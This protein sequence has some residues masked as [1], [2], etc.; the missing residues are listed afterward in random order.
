MTIGLSENETV[1]EREL[2]WILQLDTLAKEGIEVNYP[3][4]LI[5]TGNVLQLICFDIASARFSVVDLNSL[6]NAA[7]DYSFGKK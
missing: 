7:S 5:K 2:P 3:K 1:F 6:I 4:H